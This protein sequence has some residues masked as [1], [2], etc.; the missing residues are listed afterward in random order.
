M[1][2]SAMAAG[3][4]FADR[5]RRGEI[6]LAG[7]AA[8]VAGGIVMILWMILAAVVDDR[9]PLSALEPI[10]LTFLG[11]SAVEGTPLVTVW[12][13]F[14][15]LAVAAA[16]GVL[17]TAMLGPGFPFGSA[18]IIGVGY[19]WVIL[20]VAASLVLPVVNPTLRDHMPALGGA[21]VIAS[22]LYGA[23]LGLGPPLR[24]RIRQR[25]GAARPR[26]SAAARA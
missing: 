22:A 15:H 19:A 12:G 2:A 23:A 4:R 3:P 14:L 25:L 9:G 16:F 5:P 10:G 13:I 17:F 21:W 26:A 11:D 8:G 6:L 1:D 24:L 20:S 18:F 7:G